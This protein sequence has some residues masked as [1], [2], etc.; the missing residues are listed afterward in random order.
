M[1]GSAARNPDPCLG[2]AGCDTLLVAGVASLFSAFASVETLAVSVFS[3]TAESSA[4]A[5]NGAVD[6]IIDSARTFT[7]LLELLLLNF[8]VPP[9]IFYVLGNNIPYYSS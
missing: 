2:L 9:F 3:V 8:I 7:R 1:E 4:K 5:N 6:S